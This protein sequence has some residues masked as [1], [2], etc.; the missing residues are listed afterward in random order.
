VV[1]VVVGGPGWVARWRICTP[2][3]CMQLPLVSTVCG[4]RME[5]RSSEMVV[6]LALVVLRLTMTMLM[7][8]WGVFGM[9]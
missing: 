2:S 3:S 1:V 4:R 8:G 5:G 6:L 9:A 7:R